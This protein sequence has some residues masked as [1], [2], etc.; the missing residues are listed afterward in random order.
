MKKILFFSLLLTFEQVNAQQWVDT[1]FKIIKTTVN[2]GT[3]VDFAGNNRILDMDICV[4]QNDNPPSCGRPLILVIHGGAFM[5]GSKDEYEIQQ[6]MKDFAKRGYVS[7]SINYRIG[8]FQTS[9]NVHCNVTQLFNVAWDCSNMAD[10]AEW[11]R[12]CFRG[13]QDAKG[14]LR[15]LIANKNIYHIDSRNVFLT[16]QSAGGFIALG[17]AFLDDVSEKH[18]SCNTINSVSAPNAIYENACVKQF[19]WDTTIASMRLSRTDLGSIDGDLNLNT[20]PYTIKGVGNLFGGMM[21]GW[22]TVNSHTIP[23]A[24][25]LYHQPNDL[26]VPYNRNRVMAGFSNCFVNLGCASLISTPWI[27]GSGG[28]RREI[29]A[30]KAQGK[31]V[32]NYWLDSTTNTADCVAQGFNPSMVGHAIDNYKLRT[33]HMASYFAALIDTA[34][35]CFSGL[36]K[37]QTNQVYL[38][39]Q[40]N[41]FNNTLQISLHETAAQ[42]L[43]IMDITGRSLAIQTEKIGPMDYQITFPENLPN[44]LYY[45]LIT[46]YNGAVISKKLVKTNQ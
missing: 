34:G 11:Y 43:Q 26:I 41:P 22:L 9:N 19:G 35:T 18:S 36:S 7:A 25:Y 28:I 2:Y 32:P 21:P 33:G 30:L 12:G 39:V 4:P 42:A 37:T 44:G 6:I 15:Y 14:A 1:T 31:K 40:P 17:A 3:S 8:Q 46:R 20:G 16:G 29:E 23:P 38:S 10:S 13:I 45:L 27:Y 24:I 5:S